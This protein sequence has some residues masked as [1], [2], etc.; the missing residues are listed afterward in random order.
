MQILCPACHAQK[1]VSERYSAFTDPCRLQSRLNRETYA[2][3]HE[4]PKP[5]Q[6]SA[7]LRKVEQ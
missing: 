6:L 1:S 4:S 7:T 3:F 5:P 2:L